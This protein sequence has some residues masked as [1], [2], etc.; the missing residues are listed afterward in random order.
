M[1]EI[2]ALRS[3][4]VKAL[5]ERF[6]EVFG[7]ETRSFNKDYLWKRIAWRLQ[8]I[9]EGG[10]SERARRRAEELAD[11]ADL[12][13]RPLAGAFSIE[14][15]SS[16]RPAPSCAFP[17]G[18]DPRLP[19]PGTILTR[20]YKGTTIQV[21]VLEKGFEYNGE[22]YRSLTAVTRAVTGTGWNGFH[23]FGLRRKEVKA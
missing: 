21:M 19:M 2:N 6:L 14:G 11:E 12:R 17:P 22:V 4:T 8:A 20:R 13:V 23:F 1:R 18:H 7:E 5:R 10:L 9:A 3:M 15:E 16:S